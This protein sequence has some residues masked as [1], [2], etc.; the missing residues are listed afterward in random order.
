MGL[1]S[2]VRA[3]LFLAVAKPRTN[4]PPRVCVSR[5]GRGF[6]SFSPCF[7]GPMRYNMASSFLGLR[8]T[9]REDF[10]PSAFSICIS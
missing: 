4:W 6:T 8:A 7:L 1:C 9:W 5:E 3:F 10:G 2:S